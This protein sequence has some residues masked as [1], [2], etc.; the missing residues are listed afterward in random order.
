MKR[1]TPKHL[2]SNYCAV[3]F[4]LLAGQQPAMAG[5]GDPWG[6]GAEASVLSDDN[7]TRAT[8]SAIRRDTATQLQADVYYSFDFSLNRSLIVSGHV[9]DESYS[10][11]DGISS[12]Q[13]GLGLEYRFRTHAG[14]SAPIYSFYINDTRADYETDN[15]DGDTLEYGLRVRRQYTDRIALAAGAAQSERKAEGRVFDLKQTRYFAQLD[16][17]VP[18][19]FQAYL[20]Y[21]YIDG[22]VYSISPV[23]P[24]AYGGGSDFYEATEFD[25]AFS[26]PGRPWWAYRLDARTDILRFG[27]NVAFN[28]N[29]AI[30]IS[31]DDIG[32]ETKNPAVYDSGTPGYSGRDR[33]SSNLTYDATVI[34]ATYFHRF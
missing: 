7:V 33:R 2:L 5:H 31:V 3:F 29:N 26:A 12:V 4:L 13:A 10:D 1:L 20:A 6:I 32:S 23:A 15:R 21:H 27:F 22:D 30:D 16:Y 18:N 28:G 11:F 34:A 24:A 14:F 25:P 19:L 9:L 8:G 17:E